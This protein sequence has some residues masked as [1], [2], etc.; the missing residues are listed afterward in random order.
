VS[1]Y[2]TKWRSL[3]EELEDT[4]QLPKITTMTKQ[5]K[6]FLQA[7]T[8]KREEQRLLQFLNRL[9]DKVGPQRS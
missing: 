3:W 7:L 5:I 4:N 9:D 1:E 2:C 8:K 6:I